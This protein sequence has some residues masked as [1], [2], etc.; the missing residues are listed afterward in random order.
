[1]ERIRTAGKIIVIILKIGDVPPTVVDLVVVDVV[2]VVVVLVLVLV[3]VV[4]VVFV[5][6]ICSLFLLF[7]LLEDNTK[8]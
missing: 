3:F 6:P 1:M 5:V 2:V 8:D 7:C 4:V